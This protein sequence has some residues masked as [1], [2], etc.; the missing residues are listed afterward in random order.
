MELQT[1]TAQQSARFPL[2]GSLKGDIDIG[3]GTDMDMDIDS[4]QAVSINFGL[5]QQGFRAP[6]GADIKQV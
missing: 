5:L 2:K 6:L 4:G 3:I 1:H